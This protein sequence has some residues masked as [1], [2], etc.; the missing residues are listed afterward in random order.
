MKL[1][2]TQRRGFLLQTTAAGPPNAFSCILVNYPADPATKTNT[3]CILPTNLDLKPAVATLLS[4][5]KV[6]CQRRKGSAASAKTASNTLIEV[7]CPGGTSKLRRHG[8]RA[9]RHR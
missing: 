8:Q 5:A 1:P 2:A 9:A 7:S 6:N 3:P 4:S